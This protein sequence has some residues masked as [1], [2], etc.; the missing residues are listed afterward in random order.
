MSNIKEL[1]IDAYHYPFHASHLIIKSS[2]LIETIKNND[3][4]QMKIPRK[5]KFFKELELALILDFKMLNTFKESENYYHISV[6]NEDGTEESHFYHDN[7]YVN[8]QL[9]LR[10]TLIGYIDKSMLIDVVL[11]EKLE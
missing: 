7:L 2:G 10:N 3:V 11:D 5:V 4:K 8:N 6:L 9:L 1:R